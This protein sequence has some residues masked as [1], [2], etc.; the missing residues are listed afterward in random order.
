MSELIID[1]LTTRDGSNVG[2]IVVADI[3]ELL[4]LNTNKE[5]NTTAIVKDSNRGGVF[6]YDATQ[7]GVN[8][9]GTIFNGWVRQYD[10]AVNVKWFGVSET[11][12]AS[13]NYDIFQTIIRNSGDTRANIIIPSGTYQLDVFN[14]N[15]CNITGIDVTL[16]FTNNIS[17]SVVMG[18]ITNCYIKGITFKSLEI[19][20]ANQR[21]TST[22]S[23]LEECDFI[24]WRDT[25]TNNAWG[26]YFKDCQD[27][28]L[29]RCG[30]DDNTQSDIAIVDNA[31][32]VIVENCYGINSTFVINAEP[33]TS[34]SINENISINNC[35]MSLLMLLENGTGD[36]ANKS[37][38]INACTID[39]LKYDGGSAVFNNCKINNFS[40]ETQIFFG[41][42]K[43]I[44]TLNLSPNLLVDPFFSTFSFNDTQA[45]AENNYWR[46]NSKTTVGGDYIEFGQEKGVRYTRINPQNESAT[47]NFIQASNN[48]DLSVTIGKTYMVV[49]TGRNVSGTS[50]K[51]LTLYNGAA[52]KNCYLFRQNITSTSNFITQV[53]FVTIDSTADLGVKLGKWST[54]AGIV[55]ITAI[56]VHEVLGAQDSAGGNENIVIDGIHSNLGSREILTPAVPTPNAI[57]TLNC[58]QKGDTVIP[59][60]GNVSMWNGTAFAALY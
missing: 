18:Q 31:K 37:I 46:I 6:V 48:A 11:N 24:G 20:L 50:G 42:A 35:D 29:R 36:T 15:N 19:N 52:D 9:G 10:G 51:Y 56:S 44:N 54:D 39:T 55:D 60:T 4:L 57:A 38:N 47:V 1:K 17:K 26:M 2:A 43:F 3:D 12:T 7:S 58:Y 49:I 27:V 21:C 34:A 33:N 25:S 23:T 53:G 32:N 8:N 22:D 14:P 59:T 41:S 28:T 30:F 5:I 40:Q 16:E 45:L 13:E